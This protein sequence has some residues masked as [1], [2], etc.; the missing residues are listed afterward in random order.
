[1]KQ[2]HRRRPQSSA[3]ALAARFRSEPWFITTGHEERSGDLVLYVRRSCPFRTCRPCEGRNVRVV[4][5]QVRV[6]KGSAA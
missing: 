5:S 3:E 1:M 4:V 2:P 6:P